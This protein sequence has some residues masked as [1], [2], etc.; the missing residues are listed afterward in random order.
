MGVQPQLIASRQKITG[1][2]YNS[3]LLF[4]ARCYSVNRPY[5][6]DAKTEAFVT[7]P[8]SWLFSSTTAIGNDA[9]AAI[10]IRSAICV[11]GVVVGRSLMKAF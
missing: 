5:I 7:M 10:G 8:E 2:S 11:S 9:S 1:D 3:A 4:A 6:R